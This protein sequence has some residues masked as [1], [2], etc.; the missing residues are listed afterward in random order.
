VEE[1][2]PVEVACYL[3]LLPNPELNSATESGG[4][5]DPQGLDG[6]VGPIRLNV[7]AGARWTPSWIDGVRWLHAALNLGIDAPPA[8][9]PASR[10]PEKQSSVESPQSKK[11]DMDMQRIGAVF[12]AVVVLIIIGGSGQPQARTDG[13]TFKPGVAVPAGPKLAFQGV[14]SC[15]STACHHSTTVK[16]IGRNEYTIW[17]TRD[18]HARA[19]VI[20]F[21]EPAL[22]IVKNL[23]GPTARPATENLLCLNCH[24]QPGLE[25]LPPARDSLERSPGPAVL[26]DGVGCESCHG[27]AEKWLKTH[28]LPTW[29]QKTPAAKAA[30]GLRQTKDLVVRAQICT[31]CHVGAGN[32]DVNHDLIAAGHPRLRFEYAAYLANLPRHWDD[33]KDRKGHATFDMEVWSIGQIA[34][35]QAALKLLGHRAATPSKPWPEL[36]EYDCFG[37]HHVLTDAKWRRN[38]NYLKQQQPGSMAWGTWYYSLAAVLAGY[39]P[40]AG[41]RFPDADLKELRRAL[42]P[43]YTDANRK[44]A[45]QHAGAAEQRLKG[46]LSGLRQPA[47]EWEVPGLVTALNEE[48][49]TDLSASSWD[50]ATQLYLALAAQRPTGARKSALAKLWHDLEFPPRY[51]SPRG[52]DPQRL[53]DRIEPARPTRR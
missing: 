52:F 30:L 46:W 19:F 49:G 41:L 40:Q 22:Q 12:L 13:D 11:A 48:I 2:Q 53:H 24:V 34:S 21:E 37:C 33:S 9:R 29:Q 18:P 23:H 25:S 8:L 10:N 28:Y 20:L 51:E 3:I 38:P 44:R 31:T 16:G 15:A 4:R 39:P 42:Q 26:A 32:L 36:A 27:P 5:R 1:F 7:T 17:A 43:P 50:Q 35:M 6:G 14:A 47:A 45:A